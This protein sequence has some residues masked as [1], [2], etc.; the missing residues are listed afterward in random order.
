M[1]AMKLQ[2]SL[3]TLLVCMTVLAVVAVRLCI[4]FQVHELSRPAHGVCVGGNDRRNQV[5]R[6]CIQPIADHE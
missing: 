6:P 1:R 3:A 4:G 2:F 5:L